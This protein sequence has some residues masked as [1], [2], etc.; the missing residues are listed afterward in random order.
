MSMEDHF[1]EKFSTEELILNMKRV[2]DEIFMNEWVRL[3]GQSSQFLLDH[4]IRVCELQD[5]DKLPA[6][7]TKT[8]LILMREDDSLFFKVLTDL[9]NSFVHHFPVAE[10]YSLYGMHRPTVNTLH[11][12]KGKL[13][14]IRLITVCLEDL[15]KSFNRF[16]IRM[17]GE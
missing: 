7:L 10:T 11:V 1:Y 5:I 9:R 3:E 4:V 17:F 6:S 12:P 13:T 16:L 14:D 2:V 8:H 15:V